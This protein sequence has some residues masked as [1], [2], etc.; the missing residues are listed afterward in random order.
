MKKYRRV[1]VISDTHCGARSAICPKEM[2][3]KRIINPKNQLDIQQNKFIEIQNEIWKWYIKTI[4]CLQ[5]VDILFHLGDCIDGK[6]EKSGGTE[7][8]TTD[9]NRQCDIAIRCIE[10]IKAKKIIMCYGTGYHTGNTEDFEDIIA[11]QIGAK[12]GSH[13]WCD[14]NGVLFD[15]KHHIGS[16]SV[17][18]SRGTAIAKDKLWNDIWAE[19]KLQ[20]KS[21]ILL[22]G[23]THYD[24]F[25]GTSEWSAMYCP[26]MEWSTKFG[27]RRCSGDVSIGL[28]VFDISPSGQYE[29]QYKMAKLPVM[30][31]TA[32][33]L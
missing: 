11:N 19:K 30:K 15:L 12:I 28:M 4:N 26:G 14:V 29:W 31:T 17:P 1:V 23:H 32:I 24:Y 7:L 5:P 8:I 10:V 20:P 25:V 22:R 33:K 2:I 21:D 16:S 13:E 27:C 6:G 3:P 9:R 18:Y